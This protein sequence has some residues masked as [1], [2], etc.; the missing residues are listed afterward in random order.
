MV[1]KG[2]NPESC[3]CSRGGHHLVTREVWWFQDRMC[4]PP[5]LLFMW[6]EVNVTSL[7][8]SPPLSCFLKFPQT[9]PSIPWFI[10][11]FWSVTNGLFN[12][13]LSVVQFTTLCSFYTAV[14]PSSKFDQ[15][16]TSCKFFNGKE[17]AH[18]GRWHI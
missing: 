5:W 2:E 14:S 10:K 4:W 3:V 8:F 13:F 9:Y 1:G 12:P 11:G 16:D 7:G 17:K 15:T 18:L 6:F